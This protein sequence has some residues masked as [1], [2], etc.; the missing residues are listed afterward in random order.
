MCLCLPVCSWSLCL[1]LASVVFSHLCAFPMYMCVCLCVL[2]LCVPFATLCA[3]CLGVS[4]IT[5]LLSMCWGVCVSLSAYVSLVCLDSPMLYTGRAMVTHW[6]NTFELLIL[7]ACV[8]VLAHQAH[9]C[10]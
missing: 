8:R 4:F 9:V 1:E 10:V 3:L 7:G 6:P 5:R 2:R